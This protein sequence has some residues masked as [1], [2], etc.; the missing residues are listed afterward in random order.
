MKTRANNIGN[1]L[2]TAAE[3]LA[4]SAENPALEAQLLL[5]ECLQ[6]PRSWLLAHPEYPIDEPILTEADALLSRVCCG[7]PLPY[8]IGHWEFFGMDLLVSP[9]GLIPRPE[10]EMLVEAALDWLLAH[11]FQ[12]WVA[13]VGTGSGCITA[14]LTRHIPDIKVIALEI[15]PAAISLA[16]ENFRRSGITQQVELIQSDLLEGLPHPVD[17]LCANLPYIP[18]EDVDGLTVSHSEPRL[19]LDGGADGL[20]LIERLLGQMAKQQAC[21]SLALLEIEARQGDAVRALARK[22]FPLAEVSVLPDLAGK[23]RVLK[24]QMAQDI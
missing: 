6:K 9:V 19:A 24:I 8:V 17:L 23:D 15:S 18:G 20:R 11:P 4:A 13:D 1:W 14:V 7:E 16:L 3:R 12:R 5:A 22:Y 2:R 10:T 21:R